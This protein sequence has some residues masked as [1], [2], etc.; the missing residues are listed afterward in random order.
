MDI[1]TLFGLVGAIGVITGAILFGGD[2][3]S[4]V[5][6]PSILVVIGGT[7]MAVLMKFPLGMF[8]GSFKVATKAFLHK[9]EPASELIYEAKELA[10]TARR[11]G[12]LALDGMPIKNDFL[13]KGIQLCVDGHEPEF[14]QRM[15]TRDINQTIERHDN[16]QS[17]FKA[18]GEVA[19]AMGMIGTLIG[20]VQ[21]LTGMNDPKMIGPAMAVALL[22]T[23]YG[24]V[25]A[26]AFALPVADKLAFRS[27]EERLNKNLVLETISGIQD[28][29]NP[30]VLESVLQ[31]YLPSGERKSD[32]EAA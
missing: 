12:L 16:G 8:L 14:V 24:A 30:R 3:T 7:V 23:L 31:T 25:I 20:L 2:I 17:I 22:T 29:L 26:N 5:N 11:S 6:V 15:L 9:P 18:I 10:D 28:G 13:N 21:M 1:A 32:S 4:F 19:P 27:R